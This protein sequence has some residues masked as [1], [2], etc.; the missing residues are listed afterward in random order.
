MQYTVY[1]RGDL[2][3]RAE[4]SQDNYRQSKQQAENGASECVSTNTAYIRYECVLVIQAL[5]AQCAHDL[6]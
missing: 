3:H 2:L 5:L 1:Q 6:S 4:D